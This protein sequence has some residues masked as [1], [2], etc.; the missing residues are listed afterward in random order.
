[1]G[2]LKENNFFESTAK[3]IRKTWFQFLV[4]AGI[5]ASMFYTVSMS[6]IG[7]AEIAPK[8]PNIINAPI[9]GVIKEVL[10]KNS[11]PVEFNQPLFII[12]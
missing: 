6:T 12:D 4:I 10:V 3:L 5:V 8:E 2:S 7:Q 11:D 1:M 9:D